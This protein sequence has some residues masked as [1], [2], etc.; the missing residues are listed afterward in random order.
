MALINHLP[1]PTLRIITAAMMAA[2][3]IL[4]VIVYFLIDQGTMGSAGP[5]ISE[6]L[7]PLFVGGITLFMI[8]NA[9]VLLPKL[10]GAKA[11]HVTL[12]PD[13][14]KEDYD[15]QR[16]TRYVIMRYAMLEGAAF[17]GAIIALLTAQPVLLIGPAV[18]LLVMVMIR[19]SAEE[20]SRFE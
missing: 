13:R 12:A 8:V 1:L 17:F 20:Q 14:E 16:Y 19:P 4:T 10:F 11:Q 9:L 7:D 5:L 18:L 2:T 6:E 3:A 15:K